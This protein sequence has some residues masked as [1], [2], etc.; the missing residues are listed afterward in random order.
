MNGMNGLDEF[1]AD[2]RIADWLET[3]PT[4]LPD[5]TNRA[6]R[7]AIHAAPRKRGGNAPWRYLSMPAT[8]IALGATLIGVFLF[9][10][11]LAFR[12]SNVQTPG[13]SAASCAVTPAVPSETASSSSSPVPSS[14][15]PS[16]PAP[17][18]ADTSTWVRFTSNRYGY[19]MCIPPDWTVTSGAV[20]WLPITSD[21]DATG[22]EDI[23]VAPAPDTSRLNVTSALLPAGMSEDQWLAS[24]VANLPPGWPK[25]CWPDPP[26]W[27]RVTVDGYPGAIHGGMSDC[28][29]TEALVFVDGRLYEIAVTPNPNSLTSK[30][31]DWGQFYAFLDTV[32]LDP[33]AADDSPATSPGISPTASPS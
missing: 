30:V 31:F 12:Q 21:P 28:N 9:G 5:A 6:I 1:D 26:N 20:P 24:Y 23:F 18:P 14:L 29:F 16:S 27:G 4:S 2:R 33:A 7:V 8:R 22:A 11:L 3:G 32:K 17:S 13:A 15:V 10:G 25:E 19:S